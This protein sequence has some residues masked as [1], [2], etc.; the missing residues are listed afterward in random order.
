MESIQSIHGVKKRSEKKTYSMKYPVYSE[1]SYGIF[2][3]VC[4]GVETV[5]ERFVVCSNVGT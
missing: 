3:G 4:L 2:A 5:S 1:T